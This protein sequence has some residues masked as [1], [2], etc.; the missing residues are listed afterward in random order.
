MPTP[1]IGAQKGDIAKTVLMPGDPLRAKFI[2]KTYFENPRLVNEVRGMHCYTGTYKGQPVSAMGSG[3]GL[4]SIGIYSYELF[5]AYDVDHIIRVGSCGGH[6]P[7]LKL[8]DVLLI[9]DA[10][11]DSTFARM[12]SGFEG[13]VT[14]ASP[15]LL[16]RLRQS[17]QAL[18]IPLIEGRTYSS[19]VFYYQP[20]KEGDRPRWK[21]TLE[22]H[23]CLVVEM[24][25]FALFHN[26]RITGKEAATLLTVSDLL[27]DFQET[28]SEERE[29]SFTQMMEVALGIL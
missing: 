4:P 18:S 6:D 14:E 20:P 24:E 23:D 8:Y 19:D 12:Q 5:T 10:Y 15:A 9:R 13:S 27:F 1:H 25:S 2:A 28:T 29:R 17:A 22:D 7:S 3:M 11:A 21:I 16:E 26:A